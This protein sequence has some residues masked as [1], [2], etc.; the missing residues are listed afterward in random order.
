MKSFNKEYEKEGKMEIS[1][2][3][4]LIKNENSGEKLGGTVKTV[5]QKYESNIPNF[6]DLLH[7]KITDFNNLFLIEFLSS[8]KIRNWFNIF[9]HLLDEIIEKLKVYFSS[10]F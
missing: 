6:K 7:Y 5:F 9:W 4:Y 1:I 2:K 3:K 8:F 10:F